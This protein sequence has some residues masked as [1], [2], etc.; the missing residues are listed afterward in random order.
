MMALKNICVQ[1]V[2]KSQC[3]AATVT[4]CKDDGNEKPKTEITAN[5]KV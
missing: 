5:D 4:F 2:C 3:N 1:V